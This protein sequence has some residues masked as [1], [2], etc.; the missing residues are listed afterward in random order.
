[1]AF[2]IHDTATRLRRLSPYFGGNRSAFFVMALAVTIAA[3]TEP[4]IPALMKPLLDKGFQAGGIPLWIVPCALLGLFATRGLAGF[5]AQYALATMSNRAMI[6]LREK[7]FSTLQTAHPALFAQNTAS[8]L[9]NT[10]VYEVQTGA[11]LLV[12]ALLSLVKDSLTLVA[13]MAYLLWLNWKLTLIVFLI[14]PAVAWVMKA[15]SKRLYSITK[16]SQAATDS[17]AYV[18]EE[19]VLA[20]RSIRLHHAQSA[21]TARFDRFSQELRRLAI[22]ST[23]ANSAMTP[24]TQMLAAVALSAV[25]C[26]ALWQSA[27]SGQTVGGF[28]A[29]TTAMLML[30]A[31]IKHLSEVAGPVTRGL[32]AIERGLDLISQTPP[33]TQGSYIPESVRSSGSV[34]IK[35]LSVCYPKSSDFAIKGIN[36]EVNANATIALVGSSGSG[37]TTLVN[38]LAR[39][40]DISGGEILL[41]G[42]DIRQW[43]LDAL[44]QQMVFVSQD[45]VMLNDSICNNVALGATPDRERVIHALTA[46][47]LIDHI[48]TM[49]LGIDTMAGHNACELSGGQR[50][51]LGI[52]RAI[53][54]NAPILILDEATSA[55][56]TESEQAVKLAL[57]SL[58]KDRTTIIIAHRLSTIAHADTIVV[59]GHG[60]I[61]ETG[62]HAQLMALQGA[63]A[64]LQALGAT[65]SDDESI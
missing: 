18:V 45:V 57:Q 7:L 60:K 63:Y 22:K 3:F 48:N 52:A 62:T 1:M 12:N 44:R 13:L 36:L 6:R 30:I 34:C 49:P 31:P 42:I 15:L 38:A 55:L 20:Y 16:A 14:F 37:K 19:N 46:A 33:E 9:V 61:I 35:N 53:Y 39:F 64:K 43:N 2:A 17:L 8:S 27:S 32:V 58:K 23:I 40:V 10:V 5:C 24:L 11:T 29:F 41:D 65:K 47:N 21:Q 4:M 54:K 50:Q 59:M 56:D 28:V 51:R 25:V 26:V